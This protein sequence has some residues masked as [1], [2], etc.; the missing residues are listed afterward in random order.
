MQSSQGKALEWLHGQLGGHRLCGQG[1]LDHVQLP[2]TSSSAI[3]PCTHHSQNAH[4][5]CCNQVSPGLQENPGNFSCLMKPLWLNYDTQEALLQQEALAQVCVWM[6][7]GVTALKRFCSSGLCCSIF[8]DSRVPCRHRALCCWAMG[9]ENCSAPRIE[10]GD[11][12]FGQR[13]ETS[14]YLSSWI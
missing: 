14:L 1:E 13:S 11:S 9:K 4:F 6:W 10:I 8:P 7:C 2:C 5:P 12:L 3:P